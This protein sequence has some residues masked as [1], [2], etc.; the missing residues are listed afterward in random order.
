[1]ISEDELWLWKLEQQLMKILICITELN[2]ILKYII[3]M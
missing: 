3:Y 1:M 2:Y